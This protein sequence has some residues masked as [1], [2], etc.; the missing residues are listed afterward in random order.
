MP[1]HQVTIT[2]SPGHVNVA[3]DGE[4]LRTCT[5]AVLTLDAENAP[6]LQLSLLV[7]N[8]LK[9]DLPALVVLDRPT[10]NVLQAMGWTPP[11]G[12]KETS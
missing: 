11:P 4:E 7:L 9:T 12:N 6:V 5:S 10:R 3:L 8:D 1:T 2:G